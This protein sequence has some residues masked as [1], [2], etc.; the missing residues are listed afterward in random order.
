M[1]PEQKQNK[2]KRL[3]NAKGVYVLFFGFLA[4]VLALWLRT[5]QFSLLQLNYLRRRNRTIP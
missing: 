3:Q 2:L 5:N 4:S 1:T